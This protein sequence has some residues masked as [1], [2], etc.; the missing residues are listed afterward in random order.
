MGRPAPVFAA[1]GEAAATSAKAV[2][3]LRERVQSGTAVC[4]ASGPSL[5]TEDVETIRT[6]RD[7][8]PTGRIV[9]VANN[10][11]RAAPWADALFAMDRRWWDTYYR[12][13][14]RDFK[15]RGFSTAVLPAAYGVSW[16]RPG[17]IASPGVSGGGCISVAVA[18]GARRILLLGFDC[19]HTG[20][21]AHWHADH[22]APLG[23]AVSFPKWPAKFAALAQR[24][25]GR[26]TIINCSRATALT[27]FPRLPL[28]EALA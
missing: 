4:L 18:A 23:N 1:P 12:E 8:A 14:A 9:L 6:W 21:R 24:I 2:Q 15:G 28:E 27:T 16:V 20:G 17:T 26:A 19:Q 22:V 13:V 5:T 11:F 3:A 10:T 25:G 7:A